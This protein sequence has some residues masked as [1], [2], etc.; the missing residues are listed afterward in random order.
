MGQ[1]IKGLQETSGMR[2]RRR[3]QRTKVLYTSKMGSE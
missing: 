1:G 2:I 3:G